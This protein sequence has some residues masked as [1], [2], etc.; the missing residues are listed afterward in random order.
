MTT[1]LE[2]LAEV[3]RVTETMKATGFGGTSLDQLASLLA[4]CTDFV[5]DHHATIA[6]NAEDAR[7][8][9][10][11]EQAIGEM[12]ELFVNRFNSRAEEIMRDESNDLIRN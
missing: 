4:S 6:Q 2:E 3:V 12:N 10:A 1:M 7:R 9:K 8:L 11:L 5:V